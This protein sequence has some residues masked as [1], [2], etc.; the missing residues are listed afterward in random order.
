[1]HTNSRDK[2]TDS[3]TSGFGEFAVT[4]PVL[5]E[6]VT[7]ALRKMIVEG[8]LAPGARLNERDLCAVL[9]VSRTPLREALKVLAAEGLIDHQPNRGAVVAVMTEEDIGNTFDLLGCLESFAGELACAKIADADLNELK[10][11]HFSMLACH[12]R[13]DLS[14]YYDYNRTIHD[15]INLLAGN[16]VLRQTYLA[17]NRRVEGLRFRSNHDAQKWARAVAEHGQ[18]IE[19][20]EARDSARMARLMRQH[21]DE[22]KQAVLGAMRDAAKPAA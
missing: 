4:R 18:M 20:L 17:L 22:K 16:E 19:A 14:G 2:Q 8:A 1:M 12:S 5:H 3:A 6:S 13:G 11:L 21:L 7:N 9:G 15:R 10:A